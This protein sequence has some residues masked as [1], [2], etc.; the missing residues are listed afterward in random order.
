MG[1]RIVN[2]HILVNSFDYSPIYPAYE[3]SKED[4]IEYEKENPFPIT[5]YYTKEMMF[6]DMQHDSGS[7]ILT[8]NGLIQTQLTWIEDFI[9]EVI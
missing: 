8:F 6:I 2:T 7:G 4:V 9:C 5:E 3:C 1:A